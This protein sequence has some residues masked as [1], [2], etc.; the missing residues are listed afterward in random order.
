MT[1]PYAV[2]YSVFRGEPVINILRAHP[3]QVRFDKLRGQIKLRFEYRNMVFILHDQQVSA[4][5]LHNRRGT[6]K[7][8]RLTIKLK[9]ER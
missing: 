9:A 8:R 5:P 4:H 3:H 7:E 2:E 6:S 1:Q